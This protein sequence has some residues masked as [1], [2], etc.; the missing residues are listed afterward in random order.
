VT[1]KMRAIGWALSLAALAAGFAAAPARAADEKP[2]ITVVFPSS[3][4]VFKDLKFAFDLVGDEKGYDTL[5]GTIELF[6]VGVDASQPGGI[7]VYSTAEGLQAVLSLPV[8]TDAEFKKLISNLWDLDVKTAPPPTPKLITQVP[9]SLI[10][11]LPS[12]KLAP[13]ERVVFGLADAFLRHEAG[14]VH[15]GKLLHGVR[16]AKGM[17]PIELVKGHDL[18]ILID[19]QAQ[20]ADERKKSFEKARNELIGALTKGERESEELF[21]VRQAVTDHQIA[22]LERFFTESSRIFI[23]WNVSSEEKHAR[24]DLDLD[25]LPGTSLDE[26]VDLLGQTADEFA[27]ISKADSIFS[28]SVNFPLDSMRKEFLKTAS[29]L[30]RA[31]LKK[32][33]EDDAKLSAEQKATDSDLVDLAFDVL[34]SIVADLGLFN[35]F[36]RSWPNDDKTLTTVGAGRIPTAARS[37]F[38]EM[39][40]KFATRGP[41]NKVEMKIESEGDIEIHK[42]S[43]PDIQAE[44]PELVGKDGEVYVGISDTMVWLATGDKSLDRLKKLIGERREPGPKTGGPDVDFFF[45]FGPFVELSEKYQQRRP[46]APAKTPPVLAKKG[47]EAGRAAPKT[48]EKSVQGLISTADL[49]KLALESFKD[50]K[51]TMTFSLRREN[52]TVKLHTQFEEGLIRFVGKVMSKFVKENLEDE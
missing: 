42:L 13:N 32:E 38:E 30:E 8:K 50:G 40:G 35:G 41:N 16:M 9:K 15:L 26:S 18:A 34:D 44:H 43:I 17:L 19:G 3:D 45:D 29:K 12:L 36:I 49:R 51:G 11:K 52:K 37:K 6:L 22:E 48:H 21:A 10:A 1:H 47:E 46:Q 31:C 27:G 5:K 39:L 33:V 25:A 14:N 4:E 23:G 20:A 2:S 7:R 28:L 24:L